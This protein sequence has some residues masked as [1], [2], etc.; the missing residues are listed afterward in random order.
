MTNDEGYY[1]CLRCGSTS[2]KARSGDF[3]ELDG[4][5]ESFY[6]VALLCTDCDRKIGIK[7]PETFEVPDYLT[8]AHKS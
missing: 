4:T 3:G 7:P 5:D 2:F 6:V 8:E 1:Q